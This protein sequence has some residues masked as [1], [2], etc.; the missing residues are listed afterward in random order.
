MTV[1]RTR[2]RERRQQLLAGSVISLVVASQFATAAG[3][4]T[5][6]VHWG[7]VTDLAGATTV[8]VGVPNEASPTITCW[9][10]GNCVAVGTYTDHTNRSNVYVQDETDGVWLA[11]ANVTGVTTGTS[12]AYVAS[13]SCGAAGDCTGVGSVD[14]AAFIEDDQ[15]GVWQ[16]SSFVTGLGATT[17][18]QLDAVDCVGAGACTATGEYEAASGILQLLTV[19]ETGG[20]WGHGAPMV[21]SAS[22]GLSANGTYD[23]AWP[24]AISCASVGNCAVGG[25]VI[26]EDSDS[27]GFLYQEVGGTWSAPTLVTPTTPDDALSQYEGQVSVVSCP[28]AN[29][30]VAG[31]YYGDADGN[32]QALLVTESG[33]TWTPEEVPGT[34]ALNVSGGISFKNGITIAAGL[35]SLSCASAGS[36]TG[37]GYYGDGSALE[38]GFAVTESAGVWQAAAPIAGLAALSVGASHFNFGATPMAVSCPAVGSCSILGTYTDSNENL[39]YFTADEV[40]GAVGDA[41][42]LPGSTALPAYQSSSLETTGVLGGL[43]CDASLDCAISGSL[44]TY[45]LPSTTGSAFIAVATVGVWGTATPYW[46]T[47]TLL[48]GTNAAVT[49]VQCAV[50][51]DCEALGTFLTATDTLSYFVAQE[52][53]GSWGPDSTWSDLAPAGGTD[54]SPSTLSC[55]AVGACVVTGSYT[56]AAGVS[57]AFHV[58]EVAGIWQAPAAITGLPVYHSL[59]NSAT[60]NI[61]VELDEFTCTSATSCVGLGAYQATLTTT[62]PFIVTVTSHGWATTTT[63]PGVTALGATDIQYTALTCSSTGHCLAAGQYDDRHG[64]GQSLVT[65]ETDGVWSPVAAVPG[66]VELNVGPIDDGGAY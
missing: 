61:G 45:Y 40:G 48:V 55:P 60:E 16:P 56:N 38:Q 27:A 11:S 3:A 26:D 34:A 6:S 22:V 44:P 2:W 9:S 37:V 43:W 35:T 20:V 53:H 58:G 23:G 12:S 29:D 49:T 19:T 17:P 18:S 30:C 57:A 39:Q 24:N 65:S 21:G 51:G 63:V 5:S 28:A 32:Q 33:G 10:A 4:A 46:A 8:T 13:V 64:R 7:T 50:A 47:N 54:A 59:P 52:M 62:K 31:G 14:D 66:T 41:T 42:P 25:F 15:N 36:C 1:G